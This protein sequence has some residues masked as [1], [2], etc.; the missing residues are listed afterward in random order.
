MTDATGDL[1][2]VSIGLN[3]VQGTSRET[4]VEAGALTVFSTP[5]L[6]PRESESPVDSSHERGALLS[7]NTVAD[8]AAH[9]LTDAFATDEYNR[10]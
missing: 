4:T 9:E 7:G 5:L 6:L 10:C 1:A 8:R 3:L 2:Q